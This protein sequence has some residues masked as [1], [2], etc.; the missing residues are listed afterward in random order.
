MWSGK[1]RV[2]ANHICNILSSPA[3]QNFPIINIFYSVLEIFSFACL[4]KPITSHLEI[5]PDASTR[6]HL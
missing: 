4:L 6:H 2:N 1:F 5:K 3:V